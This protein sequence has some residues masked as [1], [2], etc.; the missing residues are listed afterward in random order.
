MLL[1]STA[2]L[3][4]FFSERAANLSTFVSWTAKQ[5][6]QFYKDSRYIVE[7]ENVS[8]FNS[9][10]LVE[11]VDAAEHSFVDIQQCNVGCWV[12]FKESYCI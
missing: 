6:L 11:A 4:T 9:W 12:K 7:P 3:P 10:F 1:T 5:L 2:K 8:L